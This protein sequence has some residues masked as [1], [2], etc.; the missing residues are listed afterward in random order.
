MQY[1]LKSKQS[2]YNFIIPALLLIGS[3]SLYS[4]NLEGQSPHG[5]EFLYLSWG[6]VFFD[7]LK[8][9]DN[10]SPSGLRG[11]SIVSVEQPPSRSYPLAPVG[12][13]TGR[14]QARRDWATSHA[15]AAFRREGSRFD[16]QGR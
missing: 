4:F 6:G 10:R 7:S 3:F 5:D 11:P 8:E 13:R 9:G 2:K 1:F 16:R 12:E 14:V 15:A